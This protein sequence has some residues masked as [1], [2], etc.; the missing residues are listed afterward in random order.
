VEANTSRGKNR[1]I[2]SCSP[3]TSPQPFDLVLTEKYTRTNKHGEDTQMKSTLSVV[4]AA[5]LILVVSTLQHLSVFVFFC[6][7]E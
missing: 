7:G 3:Q 6:Y 4:H 1:E 5:D 2:H